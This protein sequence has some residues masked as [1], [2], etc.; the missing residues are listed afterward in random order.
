M[1]ISIFLEQLDPR[2]AALQRN[3]NPAWYQTLAKLVVTKYGSWTRHF[4]S[5]D[6]QVKR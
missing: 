3:Q 6:G 1:L 4:Q 2:L 5:P